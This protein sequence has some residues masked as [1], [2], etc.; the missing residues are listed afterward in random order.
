[1][2]DEIEK[3][4]FV[5]VHVTPHMAVQGTRAEVDALLGR[6]KRAVANDNDLIRRGDALAIVERGDFVYH[7]IAALP[8][9]TQ[10]APDVAAIREAALRE[11][12]SVADALSEKWGSAWKADTNDRHTAGLSDGA[13]AVKTAI[14][15]L[16]TEK[17]HDR[18]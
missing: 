4:G 2:T 18:A 14:L 12:A 16:L 15:A 8:A 9:V 11:A 13:H 1:M 6:A 17:P 10:P 3:D 5:T 7:N